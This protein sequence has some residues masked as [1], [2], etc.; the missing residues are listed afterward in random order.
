MEHLLAM[1]HTPKNILE[2]PSPKSVDNTIEKKL[3][4]ASKEISEYI[5]QKGINHPPKYINRKERRQKY[6]KNK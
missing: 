4:P 5:N 1:Y 6:K 2:K 3:V